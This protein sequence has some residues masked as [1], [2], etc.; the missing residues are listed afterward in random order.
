MA[1][2]LI[3]VAK[4]QDQAHKIINRLR[5]AGFSAKETSLLF[6]GS[7][8]LK[9][10]VSRHETKQVEGATAGGGTGAILGGLTGL[11]L[12]LTIFDVPE[13]GVLV[14]LGPIVVHVA[15]AVAGIAGSAAGA[16]G[17]ALLGLRLPDH[18]AKFYESAVHEGNVLISVHTD[19]PARRA[20]AKKILEKNGG[21]DIAEI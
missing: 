5:D 7:E 12:A 4:T 9:E 2:L 1:S 3:C 18:S 11:L 19:D 14:A 17:G 6:S 15:D 16:V 13:V 20:A 10:L 8:E 21:A